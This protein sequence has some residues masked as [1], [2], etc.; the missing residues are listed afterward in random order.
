MGSIIQL[1]EGQDAIVLNKD[2]QA[3]F[4]LAFSKRSMGGGLTVHVE[5]F[6]KGGLTLS[7][8]KRRA[9]TTILLCDIVL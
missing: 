8:Q 3:F 6:D 7:D 9:Q 5:E 2:G 4:Q 1:R